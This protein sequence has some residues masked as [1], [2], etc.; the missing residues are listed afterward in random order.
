MSTL[1]KHIEYNVKIY[2]IS[3]YKLRELYKRIPTTL[4]VAI[5]MT[6]ILEKSNEEIINILKAYEKY[7]QQE[8]VG[9]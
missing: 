4:E 2:D 3:F 8:S 1:P 7:K 6:L 9:S 5:H